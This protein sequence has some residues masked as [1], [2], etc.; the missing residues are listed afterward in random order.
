M[1]I[2]RGGGR[3][4]TASARALLIVQAGQTIATSMA[5]TFDALWRTLRLA[6]RLQDDPSTVPHCPLPTCCHGPRGSADPAA[7]RE[8]LDR[9]T[10]TQCEKQIR[11]RRRA[12]SRFSERE[13][14]PIRYATQNLNASRVLPPGHALTVPV[15]GSFSFRVVP[16]FPGT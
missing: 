7:A 12:V 4:L 2:L 8:C 11:V 15:P 13:F 9:N 14:V 16:S 5:Q 10:R 1:L 3:A 6:M